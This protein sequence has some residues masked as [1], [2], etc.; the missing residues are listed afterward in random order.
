MKKRIVI[1]LVV[2]NAVVLAACGSG[3][4]SSRA[5]RMIVAGSPAGATKDANT[6]EGGAADMPARTF[7]VT[8]EPDGGLAGTLDADTGADFPSWEFTAPANPR[9]GLQKI[10]DALDPGPMPKV[11]RQSGVAGGWAATTQDGPSFTSY[12]D[13]SSRWWWYSVAG[14]MTKDIAVSSPC[15]PD[16]K[17]CA[18]PDTVPP[19]RNLPPVDDAIARASALLRTMGIDTGTLDITGNK[20]DWSTYVTAVFVLDGVATP[21]AWSFSFG[22]DGVLVNA[23]GPMF[24]VRKGDR[25]PVISLDEAVKRLNSRTGPWSYVSS[26]V[27]RGELIASPVDPEEGITISLVSA[28]IASTAY[29]T[30]TGQLL[31]L[32]AYVFATRPAGSV[33]VLAVPDRFIVEPDV[34]TGDTP[35]GSTGTSTAGS[36]GSSGGSTGTGAV[37]PAP[38]PGPPV[39]GTASTPTLESAAK[40]VGL[41]ES[42]AAKVAESAGW[43]MRVARLDGENLTLTLELIPNRVNV[44]VDKRIVT[45]IVSIG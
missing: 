22:T 44:A 27:T 20:D 6:A 19:A 14:G 15:A 31:M 7:D 41:T 24:T 40:L 32:P 2:A 38:A 28:K 13:S 9:A 17:E 21:M 23:G 37:E 45:G 3:S 5:P 10:L 26:S 4:E 29:W 34:A 30:G 33:E 35:G 1:S 43:K 12:G 39:A 8:Y 18:T 16:S 36:G 42:E 25:Y 11:G